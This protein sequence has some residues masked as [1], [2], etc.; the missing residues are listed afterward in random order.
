MSRRVSDERLDIIFTQV[1]GAF[2]RGASNDKR[3]LKRLGYLPTI[4]VQVDARD[5]S[6]LLDE[7]RI[8]RRQ[9]GNTPSG[10]S[11][12]GNTTQ[13]MMLMKVGESVE[14]EPLTHGALTGLRRTARKR[15]DNPW[16]VWHRQT[17]PNG[18]VQ[19]T[20]MPDGSPNAGRFTN[21]I[22]GILASMRVGEHRD[23]PA[24]NSGHGYHHAQKIAAMKLMDIS[25]AK[26]KSR[27]ISTTK[28][29][30]TRVA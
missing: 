25:T 4:M 12:V 22:I 21:P 3:T 11:N 23:V 29:R 27:R 5:L 20:R 17:L 13:V 30:V 9:N 10:K 16:A 18:L 6:P 19:L 26:W 2:R 1:Q 14:V 7:L 24:D 8:R 28:F 15:M